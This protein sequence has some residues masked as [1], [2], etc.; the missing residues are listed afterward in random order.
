M[1]GVYNFLTF[2]FWF[3]KFFIE[4]INIL[5]INILKKKNKVL[6]ELK[7]VLQIIMSCIWNLVLLELFL[8]VQVCIKWLEIKLVVSTG[9]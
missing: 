5:S 6:N 4:N 3:E 9:L 7:F 8:V 1:K 2:G